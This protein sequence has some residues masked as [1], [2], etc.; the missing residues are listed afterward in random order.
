MKPMDVPR[1]IGTHKACGGEVTYVPSS[2]SKPVCGKCKARLEP[3][4]DPN[5]VE[6]PK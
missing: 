1:P 6:S 3:W 2:R 4:G 5:L